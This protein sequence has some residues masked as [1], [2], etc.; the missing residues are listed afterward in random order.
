MNPEVADALV[1]A[2]YEWTRS[3]SILKSTSWT[4]EDEMA[5]MAGGPVENKGESSA[6]MPSGLPADVEPPPQSV[7]EVGRPITKW[8]GTMP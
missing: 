4:T 5:M 2:A 6:C 1:A 3:G 8:R 7:A